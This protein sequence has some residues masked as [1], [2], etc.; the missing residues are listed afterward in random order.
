MDKK[1][2]IIEC[3]LDG[4]IESGMRLPGDISY[5]DVIDLMIELKVS[6][7]K[8]HNEINRMLDQAVKAKLGF[9]F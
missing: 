4:W 7:D 8:I 3:F 9:K 2:E 6:P 5:Q 1:T